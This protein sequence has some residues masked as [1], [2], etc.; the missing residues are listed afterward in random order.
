MTLPRSSLVS[1][2]ATPYYHCISR[3][4]RRAFL[5]GVDAVTG[6]SFEH[7]RGWILGR[8]AEL[9]GIFAID[10]CAYAVMSNHCHT[11]LKLN[12]EAARHWSTD[13]VLKRWTQ[14]FSGPLVVQRYMA[15]ERLDSGEYRAVVDSPRSG[16]SGRR[17]CP[18]SCAVST[19]PSPAGPMPRM[20]VRVA[21]RSAGASFATRKPHLLLS[22]RWP[23]LGRSFQI[24]GAA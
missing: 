13:E 7:R 16:A 11:V 17:I 4:V 21:G 23:V 3:C 18:G 8:L 5:C 6:R 24:P 2:T 9:E 1:T 14:L 22:L 12:P 15:G 20:S 10:V 19:S